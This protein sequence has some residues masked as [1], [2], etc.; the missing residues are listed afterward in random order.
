MT[1]HQGERLTLHGWRRLTV[2]HEEDLAGARR[3]SEAMLAEL[4]RL[5]GELGRLDRPVVVDVVVGVVVGV[6]WVGHV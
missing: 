4:A 1:V 2:T 3:W 6:R 5:G